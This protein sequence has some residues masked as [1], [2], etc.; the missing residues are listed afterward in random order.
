MNQLLLVELELQKHDELDP[1][2]RSSIE[3]M[4]IQSKY[5]LEELATVKESGLRVVADTSNVK[6]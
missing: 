5:L 1:M 4:F 2:I 3:S 6:A